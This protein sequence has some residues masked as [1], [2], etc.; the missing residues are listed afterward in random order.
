M[1]SWKPSKFTNKNCIHE[2]WIVIALKQRYHRHFCFGNK[3]IC[4][5]DTLI[6]IFFIM[7]LIINIFL[8]DLTNVLAVTKRQHIAVSKI[9]P[10]RRIQDLSR[11]GLANITDVINQ[12]NALISAS[13][14][15][16]SKYIF[17]NFDSENYFLD[18]ETRQYSEWSNRYF[19]F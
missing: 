7:I 13:V 18:N 19:G 8:G 16:I 14:F 1:L 11:E 2:A 6:Q 9:Y 3:I 5:W 17:G 4:L 12:C 15:K 10:G